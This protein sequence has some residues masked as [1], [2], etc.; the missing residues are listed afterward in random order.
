MNGA[1]S[2]RGALGVGMECAP[3]CFKS[4]QSLAGGCFWAQ[5]FLP[6]STKR[7]QQLNSIDKGVWHV[8]AGGSGASMTWLERGG[9]WESS[10][11]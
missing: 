10:S 5:C 3:Q 7:S 8:L 11:G 9:E 6:Q 1:P 4:L 2:H